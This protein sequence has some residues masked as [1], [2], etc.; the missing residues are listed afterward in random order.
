MLKTYLFFLFLSF[1]FTSLSAQDIVLDK[2]VDKQYK[3]EKGPNTKHYGHFYEG[4]AFPVPYKNVSG[5]KVIPGRS[6]E[7]ELGYRYKLKLLSFY[8]VGFDVTNRWVRYGIEPEEAIVPD[9]AANPLSQAKQVNRLFLG[10]TS[11]GAE[12]Y[13]RIN[14]GK[15][16]NYLG[17]YLDFG[18]REEWNYGRK[19]I[20][21]EIA[22]NGNYY[23]KSRAVQRNLNFIE[24][25]STL[26]T[27]RIGIN[28][29]S[30]Y[31]NYRVSDLIS[32]GYSTPELPPLTTGI[33]LAF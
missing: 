4:I 12:A 32:S 17:N 30:I 20:L 15:R 9:I 1:F 18:I 24:K 22:S 31:G 2:N 19:L 33:Q 28:K 25:F 11:L 3:D 23:E 8:A 27:A 13:N 16:G 21:R 5:A 6:F 14:I 7:L 10:I 26:V 29:V